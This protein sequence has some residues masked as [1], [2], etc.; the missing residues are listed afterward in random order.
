VIKVFLG[1]I[2]LVCTIKREGERGG[3]ARARIKEKR[4]PKGNMVKF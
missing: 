4:T 3:R 1:Q 2:V